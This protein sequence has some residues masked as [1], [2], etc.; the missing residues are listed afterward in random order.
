MGVNAACRWHDVLW[1]RVEIGR[2]ELGGF[3]PC[4]DVTDDRM[5]ALKGAKR[6]LVSFVLAGLGFLRLVD[7]AE[8]V[9]E[10]FAKL[11]GR[12]DVEGSAGVLLDAL[13]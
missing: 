6:L 12:G 11:F 10:D 2:L 9:E 3:A 1:Q 8:V 5:L 7:E 13:R 4:E